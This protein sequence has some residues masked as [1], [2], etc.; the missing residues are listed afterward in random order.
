MVNNGKCELSTVSE[1]KSSTRK[2]QGTRQEPEPL[3]L[4][5]PDYVVHFL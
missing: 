5:V 2:A 3:H 1:R 4:H